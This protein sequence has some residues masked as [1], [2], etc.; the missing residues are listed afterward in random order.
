M[1]KTAIVI[2]ATGLVGS[3]ILNQLLENDDYASV[4]VF[5]RRSTGIDHPKLKEHIV[6]FEEIED[7]K[8]QLTGD[9]LYSALG[10]TIKQA[11]SQERQYTIDFTYQYETAKA[12][13]KN[14]VA[15]FSLVS[16][17]GANAESRAFYTKLKGELDEAVKE[18]PFEVITILRPSF[19]DG[20]RQEDRL[21]ESIGILLA[22]MFTKIPGLKK[23]RP[24]FAGKVAEGMINSL[25]KCPPG[26]HIFELDEIFYL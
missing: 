25:K 9:E 13:A 3:H 4:K 14:G 5:H 22:K 24:I 8:K 16:S 21:G 10:T 18:L 1:N 15:K 23:Y 6:K 20:A 26:Y 12:A 11:G 2:G 7:W 17:A 19:L